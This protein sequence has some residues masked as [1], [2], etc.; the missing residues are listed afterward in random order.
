MFPPSSSS[1]SPT[2]DDNL[3]PFH[4]LTY[5]HPQSSN[6]SKQDRNQD[7]DQD[8]FLFNLPTQFFNEDELPLNQ[9]FFQTH[10]MSAPP[11]DTNPNFAPKLSSDDDP[12][13]EEESAKS[14]GQKTTAA[15]PGIVRRRNL[16]VVPRRRAGKKDRHSKICTAQGI[17]DRRM[18]LSLQ[19]ARKFFDLQDMLG[20]DKASK[21]IEW[22]F[23]KSKKA[24]KELT[25]GCSAV[26]HQNENLKAPDDINGDTKTEYFFSDQPDPSMN[27]SRFDPNSEAK[28][29]AKNSS[30]ESRDK[31]RARARCRAKEKMIIKNLEGSSASA[32]L[33]NP[34][35]QKLGFSNIH[36]LE[37]GDRDD[38]SYD[39]ERAS[40]YTT[41]FNTQDL[42]DLGTI[43]KLLDNSTSSAMSF[44]CTLSDY[45][46]P[47]G[48]LMGFSGN[49]WD[50]LSN[51]RM[52]SI[53]Y[54]VFTNQVQLAADNPNSIY[55]A[56]TAN[57][58]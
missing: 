21:T 3:N 26:N 40:S 19:V 18:R 53:Q 25:K 33:P 51:D 50:F 5:A 52:N 31:A 14:D 16:G 54:A 39:Q 57:F 36:L 46:D 45:V 9:I 12:S 32:Q 38:N 24:I 29:E 48:N 1:S 56:A 8:Q 22:L 35:F 47:N 27:L 30:R 42:S 34:N 37:N 23:T 13:K 41:V 4:A 28:L 2:C 58:P 10:L 55:M 44:P 11:S 7:Q 6:Y 17:R 43:D 20:Y 49:N 15:V